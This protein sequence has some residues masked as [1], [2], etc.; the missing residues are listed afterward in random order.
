MFAL[1]IG[2]IVALLNVIP[3]KS[4]DEVTIFFSPDGL[5]IREMTDD[6]VA[7]A[8][9]QLRGHYKAEGAGAIVVPRS[10]LLAAIKKVL[11]SGVKIEYNGQTSLFIS[12]LSG[13]E[14]Y[15]IEVV[16]TDVKPSKLPQL[17]PTCR[18]SMPAP[19]FSRII[20]IADEFADNPDFYTV[21]RFEAD[22]GLAVAMTTGEG[23]LYI[24]PKNII[25]EGGATAY[26][27]IMPLLP[28]AR[29]IR[30]LP[31]DITLQFA[32]NKPLLA[33]IAH[34]ELS[35]DYYVAPYLTWPLSPVWS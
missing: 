21:V 22:E 3:K 26:Y 11:R 18:I 30:K 29:A 14:R 33:S 7:L 19:L 32:N 20:N 27:R 16:E 12:P 31:L 28:L 15:E 4:N 35:L 2:D 25:V 8:H 24:R 34:M 9:I 13:E 10:T 17:S 1:E 6:H 23:E 5:D